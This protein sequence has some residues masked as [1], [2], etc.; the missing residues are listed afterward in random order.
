MGTIHYRYGFIPFAPALW[1]VATAEYERRR[2]RLLLWLSRCGMQVGYYSLKY[3]WYIL[4]EASQVDPP[5]FVFPYLLQG[6]STTLLRGESRFSFKC[7]I[8]QLILGAVVIV[9]PFNRSNIQKSWW[10]CSSA[11]SSPMEIIFWKSERALQ[12]ELEKA[13]QKLSEQRYD[14]QQAQYKIGRWRKSSRCK[15]KTI[16]RE[17]HDSVDSSVHD[18]Y[19]ARGDFT[20]WRQQNSPIQRND[21]ASWFCGRRIARVRKIVHDLKL[22]NKWIRKQLDVALEGIFPGASQQRYRYSVQKKNEPTFTLTNE[23]AQHLPWGPRRLFKCDATRTKQHALQML[24][25]Y[26]Q[27]N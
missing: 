12:E 16:S 6:D 22:Q 9:Q 21:E 13:E 4:I 25:M 27:R 11:H 17:I 1:M 5:H 15:G 7:V 24:L 20:S 8:L 18:Y 2:H 3:Q 26:N 23:A 14:L 10:P 19:S